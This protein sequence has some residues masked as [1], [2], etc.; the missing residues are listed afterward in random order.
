[1]SYRLLCLGYLLVVVALAVFLQEY[2]ILLA[3]V[4]LFHVMLV[5]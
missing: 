1:M 4:F 2:F 5:F 3:L